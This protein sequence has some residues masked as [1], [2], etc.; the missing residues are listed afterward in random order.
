MRNAD[1]TRH[2]L[3]RIGL[4]ALAL[5]AVA[6]GAGPAGAAGTFRVAVGV[7]LDTVDPAQMTTTTV[8]NMVDYVAETLTMLGPD[9]KV[10]PWLAESWTLSPDGTVYTFKLRKG[11]VFHDGTPF[12]A[13]A[14]KWNLDRL[15]DTQVRVPIRAPFPIKEAEA[16][17]ASTIKQTLT[18]P[19]APFIS[20]S[21]TTSA[22]VSPASIDKQGN[23]YKNIVHTVGTGPYVF[24]ERKKGESFTVTLNDKYW[25]KK[26]TYDTVVFRIV[27][28]AATRESL[29]LAGQVDLIV[30]PPIADVPAL[31]R[32]PAV[33]VMLAPSDRTIFIS[34][35]EHD[36]VHLGDVR[37]RQALNY[38]VDK[39][40]I[41][42]NVLFGAADEMDAPMAPSLFGYCNAG[43][44]EYNPAKAKQLL[45]EA[46]VKPGTEIL[47]H[48][49]TGRYVQDKEASG[50][51]GVPPRGGPRARAPDD[52]LA[53]LHLRHQRRARREDRP[54]AGVPRLGAGLPRRLAA[55]APVLVRLPSAGRPRHLGSDKNAKVDELVPAADR[56]SNPEKRKELYR[57][58]SKQVWADAPWLFLYVQRFPIVYSSKVTDVGSLPN[59]KFSAASTPDRPTEPAV[60][61]ARP[62]P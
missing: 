19:S 49:P 58:I 53:V 35:A 13:K 8:A 18:R 57:E 33:K 60:V 32:N 54:P 50:C 48:H 52:G 17:D 36:Q 9:G 39:K 26:P 15:K 55:G 42:Q 45:T 20:A 2:P 41:V 14:V 44:Y 28:E 16:V 21:W 59:E 37:V 7:D 43:T 38:A 46:G 5:L 27:P 34:L 23:E 25:G 6:L 47:F 22:Q 40:A 3:S 12:D 56:E 10:S 61:R 31:Q 4:V 51:C 29:I 30:L 11:V 24:K 62:G 1:W